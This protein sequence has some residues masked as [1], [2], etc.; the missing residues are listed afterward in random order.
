MKKPFLEINL[1]PSVLKDYASAD[2]LNFY[3]PVFTENRL[4]K[5]C[6]FANIDGFSSE[7]FGKM[8]SLTHRGNINLDLQNY[9]MLNIDAENLA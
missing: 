7:S 4:A 8:H 3:L 1:G 6:F 9:P 5:H 2:S